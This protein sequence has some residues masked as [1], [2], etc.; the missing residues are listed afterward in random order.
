[1]SRSFLVSIGD[2]EVSVK[3]VRVGSGPTGIGSAY[4]V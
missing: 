3:V 2:T 1:M 4:T